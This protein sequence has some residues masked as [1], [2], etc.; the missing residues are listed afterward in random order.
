[1]PCRKCDRAYA[2]LFYPCSIDIVWPLE[3]RLWNG[4]P[5]CV[6]CVVIYRAEVSDGAVLKIM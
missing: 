3:K 1:M 2:D 4:S 6:V 5:P